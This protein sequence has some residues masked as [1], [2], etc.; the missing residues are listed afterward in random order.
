MGPAC[1]VLPTS[2]GATTALTS[3]ASP[4][5]HSSTLSGV[6]RDGSYSIAIKILSR[7][8]DP[9][10]CFPDPSPCAGAFDSEHSRRLDR[11]YELRTQFDIGGREP[12]PW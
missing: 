5:G 4:P 8:D 9:N 6:A 12:E 2:S 7:I 3:R 1:R 10:F 11:V